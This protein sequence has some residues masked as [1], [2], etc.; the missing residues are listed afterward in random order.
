MFS[1]QNIKQ[2]IYWTL[3][4]SD[5]LEISK[6]RNTDHHPCDAKIDDFDSVLVRDILKNVSCRPYYIQDKFGDLPN[7]SNVDDVKRINSNLD[8]ENTFSKFKAFHKK[9]CANFALTY[10]HKFKVP[11]FL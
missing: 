4:S 1:L 7:C 5:S 3:L 11:S 9:P 10:Q 8:L 6:L 2:C